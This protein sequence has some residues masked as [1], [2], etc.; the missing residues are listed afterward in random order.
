MH[1]YWSCAKVTSSI[2][3]LD[4]RDNFI[5]NKGASHLSAMLKQLLED[6]TTTDVCN[7]LKY[8]CIGHN[9][10]TKIGLHSLL[11]ELRNYAKHEMDIDFTNS[12]FP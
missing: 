4:L 8:L 12:L 9:P 10:F 11:K 2:E 5:D 3:T 6:I 7:K 1:Y